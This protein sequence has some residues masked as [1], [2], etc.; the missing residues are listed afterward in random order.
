MRVRTARRTWIVPPSRALWVPARTV[1]E[2][3]MYGVVRMHSLYVDAENEKGMASECQVLEVSPLMRELIVRAAGVATDEDDSMVQALVI[4]LLLAEM[5]RLPRCALDLPFPES[6]DL[7]DLCESLLE[8]LADADRRQAEDR[9]PQMSRK[10][11]YR[12][13]LQE[14][15]VTFARWKKQAMLLESVR[16]LVEGSAVTAIAIDLGY[17]SASAFSAMFRRSLGMSPREFAAMARSNAAGRG[18]REI[19]E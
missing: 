3:Q 10:T 19:G 13:F 11:L 9:T 12:R 1:H 15:G 14:T 5:R 18:T 7:V 2:I 16:R 6:A 4:P 17:E 8:E